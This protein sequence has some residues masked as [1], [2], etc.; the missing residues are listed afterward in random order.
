VRFDQNMLAGE[1]REQVR[2]CEER[3]I[4]LDR[5]IAFALAVA[6]LLELPDNLPLMP[7][8]TAAITIPMCLRDPA[9]LALLQASRR[10]F[11]SSS[12]PSLRA[13]MPGKRSP[14]QRRSQSKSCAR[15]PDQVGFAVN[16][17]RWVVE[18][19]FA[20][21]GRNRRLAKDFEATRLSSTPH[22][23]CCSCVGSL[24]LHDFRNRLSDADRHPGGV[25]SPV[26]TVSGAFGSDRSSGFAGR[27]CSSPHF[28]QT[29]RSK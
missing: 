11:R 13:D 24:A 28:G 4:A 9:S 15:N 17:R 21:I 6:D 29:A 27:S 19:F 22:P 20:W 1:W 23:S 3:D 5:D 16:P 25:T 8:V 26:N 2:R 18:R 12:V 10:I 7:A 14:R